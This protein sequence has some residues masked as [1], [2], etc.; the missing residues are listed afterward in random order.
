MMTINEIWAKWPHHY[1]L[2]AAGNPVRCDDFDAYADWHATADRTVCKSKD[3][4]EDGQEIEIS[5]VFL[6]SDHSFVPGGLPVLWET[7]V[8]GGPLDGEMELYTSKEDA[9]AGHQA[10]CERVGAAVRDMGERRD[11]P[12]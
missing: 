4:G 12:T 5:T 11:D 8:F 6:G 7:L 2:D 3:E 9:V 10:M 1:T